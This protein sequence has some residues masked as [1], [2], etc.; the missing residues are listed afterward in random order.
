[1]ELQS[2]IRVRRL[3]LWALYGLAVISGVRTGLLPVDR[4]NVDV[5]LS[6]SIGLLL[7]LL[8]MADARI[9]GRQFPQTALWLILSLWPLAVPGY[10]IATRRMK[11]LGLVAMHATLLLAVRAAVALGLRWL[12]G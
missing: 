6:L 12:V 10:L 4:Q 8:V 3:Y 9:L 11:G 2:A 5:F 1:M 7:A